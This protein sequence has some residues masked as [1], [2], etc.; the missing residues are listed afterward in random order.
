MLKPIYDILCHT[1]INLLTYPLI[2]QICFC[3]F[4]HCMLGTVPGAEGLRREWNQVSVRKLTFWSG[5][6]RLRK[7][8]YIIICI[9]IIYMFIH[10]SH[11]CLVNRSRPTT[12]DPMDCN[13]PGSSVHGDSPGQN[14]GVG[15][16]ALL[17]GIF[18]TQELNP[19]LPHCRWF[20]YHLSHQGSPGDYV[21]YIII[22]CMF[23]YLMWSWSC[24]VVSDSLRPHGL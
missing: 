8:M 12:C 5:V 4:T 18:P 22:I 17:Q 3:F 14:T 13:P 20:L 21:Y 2:Q 15:C 10:M 11:V 9:I 1:P 16:H 24:S 19:D 23:I 6:D 7:I